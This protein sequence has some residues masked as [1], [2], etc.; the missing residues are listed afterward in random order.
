MHTFRALPGILYP[1]LLGETIYYNYY[2]VGL[3]ITAKDSWVHP[4]PHAS[5]GGAIS[6]VRHEVLLHHQARNRRGTS[7]KPDTFPAIHQLFEDRRRNRKL[8]PKNMWSRFLGY[9]S[10]Q[11]IDSTCSD[12][13]RSRIRRWVAQQATSNTTTTLGATTRSSRDCAGLCAS[14]GEHS[15]INASL[16][17]TNM[18]LRCCAL[19]CCR[20]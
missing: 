6:K 17:T 18:W 12:R 16:C 10:F 19:R 5:L 8:C 2:C 4:Q 7:N 13:C 11:K 3:I 9:K 1:Y 20:C 14:W 15:T